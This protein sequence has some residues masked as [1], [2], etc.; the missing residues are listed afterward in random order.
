[1]LKT[2]IIVGLGSFAGGI[3]RF[4]I[5]RFVQSV[6]GGGF[7]WGTLIINLLGCLLIGIFY[8]FS[9]K[10]YQVA[11]EWKLFFVVGIFGGFTTFSAFSMENLDLLRA[12][13][14]MSFFLYVGL[15][16]FL[17]LLATYGGYL[18][19]KTV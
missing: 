9:V 4:V 1:M 10:G 12:G 19:V 13:N 7:P 8:G 15:S 16:V 5:S 6:S 17:G 18:M 14:I 2:L 3:L 11:A